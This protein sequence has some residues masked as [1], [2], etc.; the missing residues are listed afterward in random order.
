M[1]HHTEVTIYEELQ[2]NPTGKTEEDINGESFA[3]DG[4]LPINTDGGLK[5]FGHL[6]GANGL[7]RMYEVYKQLQEK[8]GPRQEKHL[9]LA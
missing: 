1:L 6:G 3:L 4:K 5:C 7:R 2:F 9:L 8:A